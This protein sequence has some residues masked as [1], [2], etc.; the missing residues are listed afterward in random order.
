[1]E[2]DADDD[3][4]DDDDESSPFRF[5]PPDEVESAPAPRF[6]REAIAL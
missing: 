2:A 3:D 1:V 5:S 4:D 6:D